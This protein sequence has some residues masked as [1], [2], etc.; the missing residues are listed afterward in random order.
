MRWFRLCEVLTQVCGRVWLAANQLP[1]PSTDEL[2]T[3]LII[4]Y[5]PLP[6]PRLEIHAGHTCTKQTCAVAA[7]PSLVTHCSEWLQVCV[8]LISTHHRQLFIL[9]LR[10]GHRKIGNKDCNHVITEFAY[11]EARYNEFPVQQQQQQQQYQ[12]QQQCW[13][14]CRQRLDDRFPRCY[15]ETLVVL[16]YVCVCGGVLFRLLTVSVF[17]MCLCVLLIVLVQL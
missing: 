15:Q 8:S 9:W 12:Y 17:S 3:T 7:V 2:V 14:Y 16:H 1:A 11:T 10:V 13:E 5:P 4:N 6:S